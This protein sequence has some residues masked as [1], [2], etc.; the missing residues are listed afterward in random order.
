MPG[1]YLRSYS[2]TPYLSKS[3]S[4]VFPHGIGRTVGSKLFYDERY[5]VRL[6]NAAPLDIPNK[7]TRGPNRTIVMRM[8]EWSQHKR[9]RIRTG[10]KSS[11][12]LDINT[13]KLLEAIKSMEECKSLNNN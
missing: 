9:I 12:D 3:N 8:K 6:D 4:T 10:S 7:A 11:N 5:K 2:S 13:N 1:S